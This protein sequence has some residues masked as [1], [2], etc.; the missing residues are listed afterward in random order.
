MQCPSNGEHSD[1]CLF[2]NKVNKMAEN[3]VN[4]NGLQQSIPAAMHTWYRCE[5]EI[6]KLKEQQ[7]SCSKNIRL[8]LA[9]A[10]EHGYSDDR[11]KKLMG[12]IIIPSWYLIKEL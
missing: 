7:E 1:D 10:R 12:K 5:Y 6:R 4:D 3:L 2:V 11:I 9:S 8:E